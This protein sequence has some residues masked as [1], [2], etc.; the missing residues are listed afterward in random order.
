MSIDAEVGNFRSDSSPGSG[1]KN[2]NRYHC[3]RELKGWEGGGGVHMNRIKRKLLGLKWVGNTT[4]QL[5]PQ[6]RAP[7][8]K[9]TVWCPSANTSLQISIFQIHQI[10]NIS[11]FPQFNLS[12]SEKISLFQNAQ[13][14]PKNLHKSTKQWL[15]I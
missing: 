4:T 14:P 13:K 8:W 5:T 7:G 11:Y 10:F 6:K 2:Q 15:M 3:I 12:L 1:W 9:G